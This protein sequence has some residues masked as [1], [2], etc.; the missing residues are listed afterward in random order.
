[1]SCAYY[2]SH[3]GENSPNCDLDDLY[4]TVQ[5]ATNS[6]AWKAKFGGRINLCPGNSKQ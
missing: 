2:N 3:M 6:D 5:K 1:M 4:D